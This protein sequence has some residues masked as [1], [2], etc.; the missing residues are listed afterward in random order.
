M[1]EQEWKALEEIWEADYWKS[2]DAAAALY[3]ERLNVSPKDKSFDEELRK[4]LDD[5]L[6][7]RRPEVAISIKLALAM[8]LRSE[9]GQRG[10]RRKMEVA[11]SA[12]Y[13]M[14]EMGERLWAEYLAQNKTKPNGERKL[15]GE[16]KLAAAK[17]A[18]K[19]YGR[20]AGVGLQTLLS[21]MGRKQR[22]WRRY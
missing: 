16:V 2:L 4:L 7:K 11:Q 8:A 22:R 12:K 10:N 9:G 21:M 1:T 19:H 17:E 14:L 18:H 6:K 3:R 13:Q 5:A 20:R 15:K